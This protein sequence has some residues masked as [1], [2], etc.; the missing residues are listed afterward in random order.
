[1]AGVNEVVDCVGP[2]TA[3]EFRKNA[4]K[5]GMRSNEAQSG[6]YRQT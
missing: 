6:R 5:A 4:A 1:V 3:E 2:L